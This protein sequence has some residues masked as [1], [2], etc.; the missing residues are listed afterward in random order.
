MK[1]FR[2]KG[3]A[4]RRACRSEEPF[5]PTRSLQDLREGDVVTIAGVV[6]HTYQVAKVVNE[7]MIELREMKN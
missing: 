3:N 6:P 5:V 2:V 1:R 4:R 7:S